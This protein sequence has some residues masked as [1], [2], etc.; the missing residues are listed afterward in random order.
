MGRRQ[1]HPPGE[2]DAGV[3]V[4]APMLAWE[5]SQQGYWLGPSSTGGVGKVPPPQAL[6]GPEP[7]CSPAFTAIVTSTGTDCSQPP[8]R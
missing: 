3:G 2:R 4:G 5:W 7:A 8:A 1:G 6:I